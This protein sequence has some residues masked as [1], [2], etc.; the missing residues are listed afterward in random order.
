MDMINLGLDKWL[1]NHAK[2]LCGSEH[3]VARVVAIDRGQYTVKNETGETHA[4]LMGKFFHNAESSIDFP[5]VGDWVCVEYR[6]DGSPANIHNVFPRKTFLRRKIAGRDIEH[7]MLAANIDMA[8][9]VQ[10]CHFDFNIRRLERYLVMVNDGY[11]EPLLV[12]TKTDLISSDELGQLIAE[13]RG[14]GIDTEIIALSNV[15]GSGIEKIQEIMTPRKTYCLLGSSGVGKTT[16]INRLR[17][18]SELATQTVSDTGEGRHTTTR[19][20]LM[21]LEQGAML[22]DMPGI[23]ELGILNADKGLS[24]SFADVVE[25]SEQ[26]HFTDCSHINEP[27]CAILAALENGELNQN[28]YQ[29]YLKLKKE[30]EFN[31]MSHAEK[32]KKGKDLSK[33]IQTVKKNRH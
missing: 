2:E 25:L 11:I 16:L 15:T 28:H 18:N 30:S 29:S 7:Q 17:G 20:Q 33:L 5:C 13:I 27:R 22:I 32:R 9:I 26:C 3:S 31:E 24:D 23:R 8:F 1:K 4:T 14:A 6:D 12:L 21:L 19:R 10:S